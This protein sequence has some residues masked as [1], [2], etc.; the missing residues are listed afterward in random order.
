MPS[1][2][3]SAPSPAF[4]HRPAHKP[5]P[6]IIAVVKANAYG[7]GAAEVGSGARTGRCRDAGVRGH[8][9]RHR[10]AARRRARSDSRLR[11]ARHQRSSWRL[12]ALPDADHLDTFG[13]ARAAGVRRQTWRDPEV[14]PQDR[15]RHEPTWLPPRQHRADAAGGGGSRNLSID[16]VYTHFATADEPESPAF[17]EQRERFEAASAALQSIRHLR[18]D[19]RHAANSAALLRDERVWYDFV[20]PGLLLYG[21]VPPPLACDAAAATCPVTP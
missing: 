21:I 5:V 9:G 13:R 15:H 1:G 12:S 11:R 18:R 4:S 2:R 14:S 6:K 20:R 17:A 19:S 7:H 10:A 16:A 8:R 3:T